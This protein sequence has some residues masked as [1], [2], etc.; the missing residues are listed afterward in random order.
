[1]KAEKKTILFVGAGPGDPEL[2]TIKGKKALEEAGLVL[3][4]GSLV[5]PLILDFC[6][7]GCVKE[8]SSG[9]TLEE[10]VEMMAGAAEKGIKVVRLHTGDPSL[11]GA[12]S[13]QKRLLEGRGL[14]VRFIPGVSSL[15]AAAAALGIQYTVPGGSQ[16]VICTRRGGRTP[17][18]PK[19]DLKLLAASGAAMVIFL[20]ADQAGAAASDLM[21]G[22][23]PPQTPAA[24][25]Y[26]ASWEDEK[27]I[28]TSLAELPALMKEAD[29]SRHAL[30][31][32]GDCLGEAAGR[33]LLYSPDFSHGCRE[34][35][36]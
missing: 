28:R 1:L 26:K 21:A 12:V 8:D 13:E 29:I 32:A 9:L 19:G 10:Q 23:L 35:A 14:A 6:G 11:F 33:S 5:N 36:E 7:R 4:A 18:P 3:Y 34:A 2:L 15:Q 22:G 17:V 24:C 31:I 25:V 16:T 30:I 27:I 20:S